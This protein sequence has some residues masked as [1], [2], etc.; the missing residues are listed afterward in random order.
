MD[1]HRNHTVKEAAEQLGLSPK[2]IR[3]WIWQ[4]KIEFFRVG[5]RAIRIRQA[6]IDRLLDEGRVPARPASR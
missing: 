3:D 4:R 6:E 2:T 5:G 1:R